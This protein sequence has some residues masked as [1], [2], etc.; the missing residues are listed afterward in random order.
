MGRVDIVPLEEKVAEDDCRPNVFWVVASVASIIS[1]YIATFLCLLGFNAI[2]FFKA[3]Q[4]LV[5]Y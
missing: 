2:P 1:A 4:V 5:M 3:C